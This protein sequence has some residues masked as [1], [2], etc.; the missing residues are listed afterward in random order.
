MPTANVHFEVFVRRY[1]DSS[2][3][4]KMASD[5]RLTALDEANDI[6]RRSRGNEAAAVRV[7]RETLDPATGGS[8]TR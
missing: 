3:A 6:M 7:M 4:L 1:P 2:W 8:S 5:V